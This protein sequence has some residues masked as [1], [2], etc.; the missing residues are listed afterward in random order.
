VL[1]AIGLSLVLVAGTARGGS[2][3]TT[4]V[5]GGDIRAAR[6]AAEARRAGATSGAIGADRSGMMSRRGVGLIS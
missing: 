6:G 2:T 4:S 1:T 3:A 5:A